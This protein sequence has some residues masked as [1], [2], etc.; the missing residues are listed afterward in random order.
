MF[1]PTVG[2]GELILRAVVVYA[3]LF[4]LLR[5]IG[6]KHIGELAPFD[7][8]VLL[9]LSE[10]VQNALVADDKSIL[11]GLIAAATLFALSQFVGFLAWRSRKTERALEGRPRLLVR[12]GHVYKENLAAEQITLAELMEAVRRQGCTSLSRVRFA[13][14]ENDGN[15]TVGLRQKV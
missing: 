6:K 12:N 7:L 8:L 5:L 15:I 3:A 10:C 9:I 13:M 14:L 4:V 1:L 11:G 2:V